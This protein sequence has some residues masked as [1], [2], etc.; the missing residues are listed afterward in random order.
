MLSLLCRL[1]GIIVGSVAAFDYY[2]GMIAY[3]PSYNAS[4]YSSMFRLAVD[5][6]NNKTDGWLDDEAR[7]VNLTV[8]TN[9]TFVG[10]ARAQEIV[11]YQIDWAESQG[12][13]LSGLIGPTDSSNSIPAAEVGN[14]YVLPKVSYGA[15]ASSLENFAYFARTCIS[16]SDTSVALAHFIAKTLKITAVSVLFLNGDPFAE[17]LKQSFTNV[18]KGL[19]PQVSEFNVYPINL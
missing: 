3:D 6:V 14:V 2:I 7:D 18:Y 4:E 8:C 5:M 12:Q 15:V 16:N 19:G 13:P 9:Y 17:G 11:Y 1:L 10:G